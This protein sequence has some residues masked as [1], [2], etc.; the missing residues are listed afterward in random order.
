MKLRTR[1]AAA[2]FAVLCLL[3]VVVLAYGYLLS[4]SEKFDLEAAAPKIQLPLPI[5]LLF[6]F[7]FLGSLAFAAWI[8]FR[9]LSKIKRK[10]SKNAEKDEDF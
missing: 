5:L 10:E 1:I 3:L 4:L 6:V 8:A 9:S 2:F 7:A